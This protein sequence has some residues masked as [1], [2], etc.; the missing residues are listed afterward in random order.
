[1]KQQANQ[2]NKSKTTSDPNITIGPKCLVR[3]GELS[4]KGYDDPGIS[5]FEGPCQRHPAR[6]VALLIKR[7]SQENLFLVY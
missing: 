1:M 6:A 3:G 5:L 4:L 7:T 2:T